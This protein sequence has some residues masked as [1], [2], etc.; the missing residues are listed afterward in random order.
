MAQ[1]TNDKD[2]PLDDDIRL[3]GRLLGDVVHDQHGRAHSI[4]T[5]STLDVGQPR[6]QSEIGLL[7]R[8]DAA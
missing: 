3:L 8:E 5:V 4:P 7:L 1:V 2:A 6:G